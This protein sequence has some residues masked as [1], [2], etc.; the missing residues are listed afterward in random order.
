MISTMDFKYE[1]KGNVLIYKGK[2]IRIMVQG[3]F[4]CKAFK[5]TLTFPKRRYDFQ[6]G[7]EFMNTLYENSKNIGELEVGQTLI[8]KYYRMEDS[9]AMVTRIE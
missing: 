3:V 6:K 8:Q 4:R 1:R 7:S 2:Q 5:H 9:I